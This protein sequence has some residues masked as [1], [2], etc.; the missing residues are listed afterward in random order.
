MFSIKTI[1]RKK[2]D[3]KVSNKTAHKIVFDLDDTLIH[4]Y[5][6]LKE[7]KTLNVHDYENLELRQRIF[8][9]ELHDVTSTVGEG[10]HSI[11]WGVY[12]PGWERFRA[13]CQDY[14]SEIAVWSAGKPK[15]VDAIV[16]ILFP[17]PNFQPTIVYTYPECIISRYEVLKPLERMSRLEGF[18]LDK[19]FIIDDR[20]DTFSKNPEN[21][22]LIPK[23]SPQPN[24]TGLL[25]MRDSNLLKLETWL[26]S[27]KVRNCKDIRTLD[28]RRIFS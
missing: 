24:R 14:F 10:V 5:D 17:D 25:D 1:E 16:N 19:T 3:A 7:F 15:Y 23:Y 26:N 9:I 4:C 18:T 12:R 11:M 28:K 8:R 2:A 13:F 20:D 6:S 27:P 22:I 21:G